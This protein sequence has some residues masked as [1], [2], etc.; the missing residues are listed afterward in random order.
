MLRKRVVIVGAGIS[1][2]SAARDLVQ[3]GFEVVLLEARD[4]PG[5]RMYEHRMTPN[6][7]TPEQKKKVNDLNVVVQLGANWIHGL[8]VEKNPLYAV[9]MRNN[10][11]LYQTSCDDEPGDDVLLYDPIPEN[12]DG[13]DQDIF[14]TNKDFG[15]RVLK[16]N[17]YH[18]VIERYEWMR[19]ELCRVVESR[20]KAEEKQEAKSLDQPLWK[21]FDDAMRASEAKFGPVTAW[22]RR[23]IYWCLDRLGIDL[24]APLHTCSSI[25]W[26]RA[27]ND[28]DF[29]EALVF[30]GFYQ[31]IP[32][33]LREIP[34]NIVY[35]QVVKKIT[36]CCASSGGPPTCARVELAS[37]E[38]LAADYVLV[39]V[40]I[41]V[42]QAQAIQFEPALPAAKQAA[43]SRIGA[44]LMN[45]VVFWFESRFWPSDY[46]FF[47]V[48]REAHHTPMFSTF[49]AAPVFDQYGRP[50]PVLL[51]QTFGEFG[52]QVEKM[53]ERE[54]ADRVVEVLGTMFGPEK[55]SPVLGCA[56]STW[57]SDPFAQCAWSVSS[58]GSSN[59]DRDI[60]AEDVSGVLFF[61]GEHTHLDMS[62]TVH[63][64]WWTGVREAKKIMQ[65]GGKQGLRAR[66]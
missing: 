31:V 3:N 53:S 57:R 23:C 48:A 2:I 9:A 27:D 5:G 30:G 24:A 41:G 17:V 60:L 13:T 46:N 4:R 26:A 54:L 34:L 65:L 38:T 29:G 42:L 6:L 33:L 14:E 21:S 8:K 56:R 11:Q 32:A 45:L 7:A 47:G 50:V 1:G 22:E 19:E 55:V 20:V 28:G 40:P 49:L 36:T 18:K 62:G 35:N 58:I 39:T 10:F 63:G 64:A 44:G 59:R 61:A 52:E 25:A 51:C 16:Q 66:L 37:G 15:K 12:K 43:I